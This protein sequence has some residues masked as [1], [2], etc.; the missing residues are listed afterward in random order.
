[1]PQ[2]SHLLRRRFLTPLLLDPHDERAPPPSDRH[3]HRLLLQAVLLHHHGV[4]RGAIYPSLL[5]RTPRA[6]ILFLQMGGLDRVL[7]D[8][9]KAPGM[10]WSNTKIS[11]ALDIARAMA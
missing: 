7:K 8:P 6:N 5:R 1:M 11:M 9:T 3:V 4:P 10:D 2:M